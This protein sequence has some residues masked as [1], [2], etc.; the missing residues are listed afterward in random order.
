MD[1][2]LAEDATRLPHNN[3]DEEGHRQY[4][5]QGPTYQEIL[6]PRGVYTGEIRRRTPSPPQHKP[7]GS[8]TLSLTLQAQDSGK[9]EQQQEQHQ[10]PPLPTKSSPRGSPGENQ[11]GE[12]SLNLPSDQGTDAVPSQQPRQKL[13]LTRTQTTLAYPYHSIRLTRSDWRP[14]SPS[15]AFFNISATVL[16]SGFGCLAWIWGWAHYLVYLCVIICKVRC[17]RDRLA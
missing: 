13:Y 8:S 15:V 7:D 12:I 14:I 16:Y 4:V 3:H 6:L 11:L 1:S 10:Q 9:G 5:L 2:R 17:I